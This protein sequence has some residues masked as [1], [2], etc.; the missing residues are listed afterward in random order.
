MFAN[1]HNQKVQSVYLTSLSTIFLIAFIS[2]YVQYPGLL[3]SSCGLE[4]VDRV[5][6]KAF[7]F[8]IGKERFIDVDSLCELS[9]ILGII[10]SCVAVR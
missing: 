2:Y 1:N 5:L 9:C 6:F 7:P 4:P 3:S 10:L 8:F